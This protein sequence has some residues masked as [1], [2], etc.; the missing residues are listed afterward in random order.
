MRRLTL[1]LALLMCS[2]APA[3]FA[4]VIE[5]KSRVTQVTLYPWGASVIRR[6]EFAAPQ[7][8][9]ELIVPDLPQS[10][11]AGSLRVAGDGARIGAVTL[12][13]G[14]LPVADDAPTPEI[15][16]A[17]AEV[18]RM[19]AVLR[20]RD[21]A[22]AAIRLRVTAAQDQAAFLRALAARD[23]PATAD[24]LRALSRMVGEELLA[25]AEAAHA[26][27]Q[28]AAAAERAREDDATALEKAR[29]TLAAL[30]E[31]T[32]DLAAL[33][34]AV[35]TGAE[36]R[37]ALEIT[38]FTNDASWS[39]VYDLRLDRAA[40]KLA[41]ERGVLVTQST[42]ED[43]AGVDLTLSTARPAEQS[44]PSE[45]WPWLR[46]I[47]PPD[48]PMPQARAKAMEES[49]GA[50]ADMALAAAP[51]PMVE[52][53]EMQ[54]MGATVTWAYGAPVDIRNGVDALRLRLGDLALMPELVAQAVPLRD[55]TAFLVARAVND[56][57]Q[58][59]LPGQASL[60]VDGAMV[61]STNLP[62]VASGDELRL[63]FGPIDGIRLT[64]IVPEKTEGDRG[65]ISKSNEAKETAILKIENLTTENWA[66]RV[67]DQVPYSEQKD[68][69]I[70]HTST[71]PATETDVEGARG[72]LAWE[73]PLTAGKV[74]EIRLETTLSWP[75]GQVLQ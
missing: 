52:A 63:G 54:M 74:Q 53:A 57:G 16:A 69:V 21:A 48:A 73:M 72:I 39:P 37:G 45:L 19:E 58:V 7:G 31:G 62:L 44:D 4:D 17:K 49:W 50:G 38:S 5:A 51:A 60:F 8:V 59:I 42:G 14:R 68:L 47:A 36:G 13:Q 24:D 10:T 46:R 25:A 18:E 64:R 40:G 67:L 71:P 30:T 11:D 3:A 20:S 70:R 61:G 41:V 23:G 32:A 26:A 15:A 28:E 56:S 22:I 27:E 34:V 29:Q 66:L 12:M 35:E 75:S 33:S 55:A 1:P 43:W 6:V 65:V 2:T 9:H